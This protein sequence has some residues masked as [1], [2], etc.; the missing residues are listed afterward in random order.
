MS[1]PKLDAELARARQRERLTAKIA[2]WNEEIERTD[3]R[4]TEQRSRAQAAM[5]TA[6]A[7]LAKLPTAKV[8][9]SDAKALARYL[10]A[11]GA[12]VTPERLNDLLVLL[13]VLHDRGGRR[14]VAC[15]RHGAVRA[16]RT[17]GSGFAGRFGLGG[18]DTSGGRGRGHCRPSGRSG[19]WCPVGTYET[20]GRVRERPGR[21]PRHSVRRVRACRRRAS[22]CVVGPR[23]PGVGRGR[24]A[25]RPAR[26][27]RRRHAASRSRPRMLSVQS[28]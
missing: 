20:G 22:A 5:N 24:M 21:K 26:S 15:G 19:Q 17:C 6:S 11:L 25:P 3:Q 8:A 4:R 14:L 12:D 27:G 1:C 18:P 28:P 7:E 10:A 23:S 16:R 13:A 9:N 2:G